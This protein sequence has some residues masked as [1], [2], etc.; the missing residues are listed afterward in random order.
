MKRLLIIILLIGN[1]VFAQPLALRPGDLLFFRDSEGMGGA[2]Q[3]STGKYTHVAIAIDSVWTID[4]TPGDGVALSL[5]YQGTGVK[6]DIYR[7]TIPFDTAGVVARAKSF[8]GQPYDNA[9]LPD[10]G[11]MYCSELVYECYLD[12]NG[13]HL[14]EAKP[15]NWRNKEGKMPKY[16]KRHFKKLKMPIPEGVPG[17]N[18]TDLSRSALLKPQV[19]SIQSY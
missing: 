15:M 5:R 13:N 1:T 14:F 3:E 2:V 19:L 8:I 9:F 4:A 10:N 16:W 17:T 7:L 18:P 11:A 12:N 6:A